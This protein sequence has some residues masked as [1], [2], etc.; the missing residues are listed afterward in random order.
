LSKID[1]SKS[2][3]KTVEIMAEMIVKEDTWLNHTQKIYPDGTRVITITE[4]PIKEGEK[5]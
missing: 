2:T 5:L 3:S 1:K 4:K